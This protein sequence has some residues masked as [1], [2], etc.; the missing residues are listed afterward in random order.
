MKVHIMSP[1]WRQNEY[2]KIAHLPFVDNINFLLTLLLHLKFLSIVLTSY[3]YWQNNIIVL[4]PLFNQNPGNLLWVDLPSKP[5]KGLSGV[6]LRK[7]ESGAAS[8]PRLSLLL[9]HCPAGPCWC[10]MLRQHCRLSICS[11]F[12]WLWHNL[13]GASLSSLVFTM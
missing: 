1:T 2:Q 7:A 11:Y 10:R 13:R 9:H 6:H 4:Q 3:K 8:Y 12:G 5:M